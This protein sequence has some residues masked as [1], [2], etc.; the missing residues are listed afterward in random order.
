MSENHDNHSS[1]QSLDTRFEAIGP[2]ASPS[3]VRPSRGALRRV[4][5]PAR[6]HRRPRA[7]G[8]G[9]VPRHCD[10]LPSRLRRARNEVTL[11]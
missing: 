7:A 5:R 3:L 9:T 4:P 8:D 6:T 1:S 10:Y 11:F 2:L